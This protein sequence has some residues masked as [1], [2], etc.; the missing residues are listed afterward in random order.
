M[1]LYDVL[2][3]GLVMEA[4]NILGDH[5]VDDPHLLQ[6]GQCAVTAIW[7]RFHHFVKDAEEAARSEYSVPVLLGIASQVVV[8]FVSLHLRF[9]MLGP[10]PL[11]PAKIVNT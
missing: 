4:I 3:A 9:R 1:I 7:L 10:Y 8:C 11:G 6:L 5:K 2:A